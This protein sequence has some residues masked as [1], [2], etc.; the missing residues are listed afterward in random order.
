MEGRVDPLEYEFDKRKRNEG[1][2][3]NSLLR[4]LVTSDDSLIFRL[5]S[6]YKAAQSGNINFSIVFN[7]F[8]WLLILHR[9]GKVWV[10][11]GL[12]FWSQCEGC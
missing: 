5:P 1:A 6:S 11:P 4:Y 9:C 12:V 3:N 8:G 7:L 10:A 2:Q